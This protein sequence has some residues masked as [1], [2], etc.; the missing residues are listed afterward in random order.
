M[1]KQISNMVTLPRSMLR[2]ECGYSATNHIYGIE[3]T[4]I[5]QYSCQDSG[6]G[7]VYGSGGR[8]TNA[9]GTIF[10]KIFVGTRVCPI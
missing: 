2:D 9:V 4:Y 10:R 6:L 3:P 1:C 5:I 8:V 7:Y